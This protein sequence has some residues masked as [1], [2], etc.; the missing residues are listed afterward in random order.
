MEQDNRCSLAFDGHVPIRL[1]NGTITPCC[2]IK[3]SPINLERGGLTDDFISL[4]QAVK[5]NVRSPLCEGCWTVTDANGPSRRS[6][7]S[8][9]FTKKIDWESL[10]VM[11]PI[12]HIEIVFSTKCQMMCAYCGPIASTMWQDA[13]QFKQ[14]KGTIQETPYALNPEKTLSA[15]DMAKV[16]DLDA[17]KSIHVSGGEPMLEDQCPEFF[18]SLPFVP[19]RIMSM[20]TN[21]SYG[22]AV[23]DKLMGIVQQHPNMSVHVSLDEIGDN[24]SR[25]YFNWKL[26]ERNF[27]ILVED[28]Q[29]RRKTYPNAITKVKSTINIMNY[30]NL[31]GVVDYIL[32][33]RKK[34]IEGVLFA[35]GTPTIHELTSLN[36]GPID[37]S[38][39]LKFSDEDWNLLTPKEQ[40]LIQ[41]CN[42]MFESATLDPELQKRTN[43]FLAQYLE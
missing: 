3:P 5:D 20:V 31:Q 22:P 4:R 12:Q 24:I 21:L 28:L 15:A 8:S 10:D 13:V 39:L 36:S 26:W 42:T 25:K 6:N 14:Y 7:A 30:K 19:D 17:L 16:L 43:E 41:L 32:A 2:K 40:E 1:Y 11:M 23:F 33:L 18:K 34:G 37:Q 27:L 35:P 29:E 9:H 38:A